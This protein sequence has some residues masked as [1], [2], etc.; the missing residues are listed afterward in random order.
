LSNL[1]V[2]PTS[3]G[4]TDFL[5]FFGDVCKTY[6]VFYFALMLIIASSGGFQNRGWQA[7]AARP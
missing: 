5:R 3:F 6:F 1:K 7:L 4:V 2:N